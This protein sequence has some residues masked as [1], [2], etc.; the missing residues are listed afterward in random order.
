MAFWTDEQLASIDRMLNPRSIA[1]VGATTRMQ[2]GG[3]FVAAAMGSMERGVN[4]YPVNP[5][6]EEV[7]GLPCYP[8]VSALPEAPDVVGVVVPYHAVLDT[9]RESHEKGAKSAIVISAGFSERAV[10]D[11]RDLQA[12]LGR[13]ARESGMRVSGPNCLGL[14][15][16]KD[17][18]WASAS[19]LG[20]SALE[21]ADRTG[22]PERGVGV[23]AVFDAGGG[24]GHRVH[25]HRVDGKRG[26]PGLLRFRA[27]PAG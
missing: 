11:R 16:L 20:A 13:F 23:R 4:V 22:V 3:R 10:D 17:D 27:V 18:I 21:R 25:I 26:G 8:S 19:S 15:N 1:V 24:R 5:R 6:Y 12:E 7:Q 2:Y 9:L 14:A